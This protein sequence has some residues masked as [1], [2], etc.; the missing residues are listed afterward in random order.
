MAAVVGRPVQVEVVPSSE[1]QRTFEQLGLSESAA[2]AYARMTAI[3]LANAEQPEA[4]RRGRT[5]LRAHFEDVVR[6]ASM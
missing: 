4:P 2:R 3:T 6:R 1:W 5:T